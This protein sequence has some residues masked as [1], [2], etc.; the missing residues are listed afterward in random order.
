VPIA[1]ILIVNTIA[2]TIGATVAGASYVQVFNEQSLWIFS[3]A[4]TI[5]VLLFT[6]IIPKT[7]GVTFAMALA[8]PVAHAI[9]WLTVVLGPFVT[10]ASKISSAI[11]GSK[12]INSSSAE[13]IRLMTAIGRQE[14]VVGARTA[15]IIVRATRLHELRAADVLVPRQR[16]VALT[17]EQD[18]DDVKRTIRQSGHSRFPFTP[19]GRLDDVSGVVHAKEL[20]L[21]LLDNSAV[22]DWPALMREPLI[23][24]KTKPLN[25]LLQEFRAARQH[26]AI[27]IDEYGGTEGIVTLEDVLEE[28]VGE[29]IDESD[30]PIETLWPQKDG[31]VHA[32]S[33]IELLK[34]TEHLGIPWSPDVDVHTLGGL[35][36]SRLE[37]IPRKGDVITWHGYRVEVLSAT[38]TRAEVVRLERLPKDSAPDE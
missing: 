17:T 4:F 15:G 34:L 36:S 25:S 28:L 6:E 11:R 37:R 33:T 20:L 1:A 3:A 29:I 10:L 21:S 32:L 12:K 16:V 5:A 27:V 35:L 14:G 22:I 13:E 38:E 23:V 24:P 26:M 31:A 30:R 8:T 9:H 7:L 2:H 18:L 19:T